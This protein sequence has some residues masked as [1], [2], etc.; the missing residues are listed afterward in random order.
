MGLFGKGY[1]IPT[2]AHRNR[3]R[4]LIVAYTTPG[5]VLVPVCRDLPYGWVIILCAAVLITVLAQRRIAK[6]LRSIN[7]K[8]VPWSPFGAIRSA[9]AYTQDRVQF[10]FLLGASIMLLCCVFWLADDSEKLW[11][12]LALA[13]FAFCTAMAAFSLYMIYDR[14]PRR[15]REDDDPA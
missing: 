7:A 12:P 2:K 4:T 14:A 6:F 8:P 9:V 5:L 11:T 13:V 1:I 15:L 3:I 10:W